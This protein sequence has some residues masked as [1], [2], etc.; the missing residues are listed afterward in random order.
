MDWFEIEA[1]A[2]TLMDSDGIIFRLL[3]AIL[4]HDET[5]FCWK[6]EE[7]SGRRGLYYSR[8]Y[9]KQIGLEYDRNTV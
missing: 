4:I 7:E 9:Y 5:P 8:S 3:H 1:H 2:R 6:P